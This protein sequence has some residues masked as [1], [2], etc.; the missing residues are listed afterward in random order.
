MDL[1]HVEPHGGVL[2]AAI[3][4]IFGVSTVKG[5]P[6]AVV[7]WYQCAVDGEFQITQTMLSK[8]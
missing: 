5:Q 6:S 7:K 2:H 8:F 4:L 1:P 3:A